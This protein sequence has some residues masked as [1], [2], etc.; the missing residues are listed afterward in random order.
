M[1]SS[2][3]DALWADESVSSRAAS[4]SD[5]AGAPPGRVDVIT[6]EQ[7]AQCPRWADAFA[8]RRKDHRY[9]ELLEDTLSQGL[10]HRYFAIR[11]ARGEVRAVQ[12]FVI[13]DQDLLVG[14]DLR[15]RRAAAEVRRLWPGFLMLRTM[16]VGCAAGEGHLDGP[17]AARAANAGALAAAI[18]GH[19]RSAKAS[20]IALKEF[21]AEYRAP[22][23]CFLDRGFTRVPSMP[24]TKLGLAYA[25]FDD[26]ARRALNSSTRRK[27]RKKFDAAARS[28]PITMSEVTDAAPLVGELYP[29]YLSVYERSKLHFEKLTPAFFAQIGQRMPDKAR[30]LI[31]RQQGR[32]VA[33]ALCM[34]E[35]DD[36]YPEYVGFDYGVA[37]ELH[38]YHYIVRD[39]ISWAITHGFTQLRSSGLNYDPKLHFR[40]RLDPVDLYVRHRSPALNWV[41][42][43]V[44]PWIEP[45]RH[46]PILRKFPNYAEL[47]G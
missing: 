35:G 1:A 43:R 6:R 33:F 23:R 16:M 27:L 15:V 34:F 42:K 3:V 7:L 12:P 5:R 31:W 10:E 41:L 29:L 40:H 39:M 21:P 18:L 36:F 47:W 19:A 20:L 13:L 14:V 45:T 25:D 22:L 38:L 24:M 2:R 8:E 46:D 17:P 32:I 9:H 4:L 44:L 37:L 11:D 30:F 28:A 26:Y